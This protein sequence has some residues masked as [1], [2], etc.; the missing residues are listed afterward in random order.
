MKKSEYLKKIV[1]RMENALREAG[2]DDDYTIYWDVE[3]INGV[4]SPIMT[5]EF[6]NGDEKEFNIL[7]DYNRHEEED[8]SMS[9]SFQSIR[10]AIFEKINEYEIQYG[11]NGNYDSEIEDEE[12]YDREEFNSE[13]DS[14][15]EASGDIF[16]DYELK[17]VKG[18]SPY[19]CYSSLLGCSLVLY[20]VDDPNKETLTTHSA[21]EMV[22]QAIEVMTL[23]CSS[24]EIIKAA[25]QNRFSA[26]AKYLFCNNF[27]NKFSEIAGGRNFYFVPTEDTVIILPEEYDLNSIADF[28]RISAE[29]TNATLFTNYIFEYSSLRNELLCRTEIFPSHEQTQMLDASVQDL[30]EEDYEYEEEYEEDPVP[31]EQD[32]SVP[33]DSHMANADFS[34]PNAQYFADYD[35]DSPAE[36]ART[37][38]NL[39]NW[40]LGNSFRLFQQGDTLFLENSE[41]DIQ[42]NLSEEN[43]NYQSN[44][45]DFLE[46]GDSLIESYKEKE[47]LFYERNKENN[48]NT[49]TAENEEYPDDFLPF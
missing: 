23:T 38:M 46:F 4:K 31:E 47:K 17:I 39:F 8:I 36:F 35:T 41:N 22:M 7:S 26:D 20:R 27:L 24:T 42:L 28:C 18:Q 48:S 3:K 44:D 13:N 25:G 2:K 40:R 6:P 37:M 12:E 16:R 9:E 21:I 1:N 14:L 32:C 34:S 11:I 29:Q 33:F 15:Q 5:I 43:R 49:D 19:G 45:E 30:I 10:N